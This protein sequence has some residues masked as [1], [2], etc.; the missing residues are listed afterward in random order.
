MYLADILFFER[1]EVDIL[2]GAK[3][4]TIRDKTE[5]NFLPN[6]IVQVSTYETRRWFCQI[7]IKDVQPIRYDELSEFHANQENMS[8][9][10]LKAVIDEIYPNVRDL[11]VITYVLLGS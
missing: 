7:L 11:Y 10:E 9:E 1:F 4:I 6:T 5:K 3:T 2:S 8:L